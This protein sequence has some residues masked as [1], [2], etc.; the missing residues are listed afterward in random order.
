MK[1]AL[2]AIVVI[3]VLGIG[4]LLYQQNFSSPMAS[5]TP[6]DSKQNQVNQLPQDNGSDTSAAL[7][8]A[9]NGTVVEDSD[10][11]FEQVDGDIKSL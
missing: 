2:G 10:R 8:A 3:A 11:D 1:I 6:G 5:N 7:E 4:F 9:V